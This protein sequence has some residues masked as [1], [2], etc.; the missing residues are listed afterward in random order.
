MDNYY[1]HS[2]PLSSNSFI[3]SKE[4]ISIAYFPLQ[5]KIFRITEEGRNALIGYFKKGEKVEIITK[6]LDKNN[7][8][9]EPSP[10]LNQNNPFKSASFCLSL[11]SGC[12]LRCIYCY[13]DATN[14][15]TVMSFETAKLAID[16]LLA[17][18]ADLNIKTFR[19]SFLGGGETLTVFPLL[20]KIV[21]YINQ[22]TSLEKNFSLVTNGTLIN[23]HIAKFFRRNNFYITVSLDG[24]KEIQDQQRPK[25]N[26]EGSFDDCIRG[27]SI[28]KKAKVNFSIRSTITTINAN[29]IEDLINIAKSFNSPIK[30]E[31]VTPTGRGTSIPIELKENFIPILERALN[32]GKEVGITVRSSYKTNLSIKTQYCGGNGNLWCV[33][34]TGLVSSCSRVTKIDDNLS[35]IYM[36]GKT[37]KNA[38]HIE[39]EK[40]ETLQEITLPNEKCRSC[41]AKWHCAGGCYNTKLLNRGSMP[42]EH[43][44]IM[45]YFVWQD[46]LENLK[47]GEY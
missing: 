32:Y 47:K 23:S 16:S 17:N 13:A 27:M 36:I 11:T 10:P 6:F 1:I 33:L 34:P 5:K 31:P 19:L 42:K 44:T 12:N 14:E 41:F 38:L 8:L 7:L 9:T 21:S 35:N 25:A 40:I 46:I 37:D 15:A 24:P 43:C 22:N 4:G 39:K 29:K 30:L 3:I 28:L 18:I 20:Y 45:R 2:I 26:G